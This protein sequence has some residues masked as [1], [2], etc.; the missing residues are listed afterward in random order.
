MSLLAFYMSLFVI[1]NQKL[2]KD[3]AANQFKQS[4]LSAH[5]SESF[6]IEEEASED[7]GH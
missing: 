4:K 6:Q 7:E 5:E 1:P 3:H 2:K